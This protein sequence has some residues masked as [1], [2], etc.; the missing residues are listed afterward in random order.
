MSIAPY[1]NAVTSVS[2]LLKELALIFKPSQLKRR[3]KAIRY[4][5]KALDFVVECK[6]VLD[7]K[8]YGYFKDLKDDFDDNIA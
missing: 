6:G 3:I 4:A 5:N 8:Q 7:K 1:D 2:E